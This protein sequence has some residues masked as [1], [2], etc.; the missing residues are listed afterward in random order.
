ML[1][2]KS[3]LRA[4]RGGDGIESPDIQSIA[5]DPWF[6]PDRRRCSISFRR[7]GS[8]GALRAGGRRTWRLPRRRYA[9]GHSGGN[10][11]GHLG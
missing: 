4:V 7:F 3:L 9:G 11:R 10:R 8:A 6:I 5:A 2:A 1:H